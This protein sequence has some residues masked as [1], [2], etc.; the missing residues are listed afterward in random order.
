MVEHLAVRELM[1]PSE[2]Y[3]ENVIGL[4]DTDLGVGM[5]VEA[6]RTTNGEIAPTLRKLIQSGT[7]E[8]KHHKGLQDVLDWIVNTNVIIRELTTTNMV[9]NEL[10]Q[11]FVIID[12]VGSK[13]LLT[14][15]S[16]SKRYNRRSNFKKSEKLKRWV[17]EGLQKYASSH[18]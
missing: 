6:I 8:D 4:V 13:P 15:R 18:S 16:F 1:S 12:G 17:N 2:S 7:F 5:I 10:T 11:R 14:L 3:I 9:W